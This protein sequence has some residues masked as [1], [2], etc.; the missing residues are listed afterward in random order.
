MEIRLK[1]TNWYANGY[2][3]VGDKDTGYEIY[4]ETVYEE[5]VDPESI[6]S[7]NDFESALTW[8]WN[9]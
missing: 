3:I 1:N 7:Y 4:D 5:N 9:S 8:I 6:E 2:V